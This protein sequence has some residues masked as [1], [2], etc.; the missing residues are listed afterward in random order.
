YG[1]TLVWVVASE[2]AIMNP[3]LTTHSV[4]ATLLNLMTNRIVRLNS[5]MEILPDLAE[6]WEVSGDGLVYTFYLRKGVKFHDGVELTAEDVIFTYKQ[7]MDPANDSPYRSHFEFIKNMGLIDQY[8]VRIVLSKPFEPFLAKLA[9]REILPKYI[10]NGKDLRHDPFNYHPIGT[11]PFKLKSWDKKTNRIELEANPDYF[12]GRPFLDRIVVKSY[13]DVS[14]LW[15]ALMRHEVDLMLFIKQE[16]YSVIEHDPAFKA[17]AVAGSMYYAIVYNLKDSIWHDRQLRQ[18]VAHGISVKQ[19]I[20]ALPDLDGL[21]ATGPFHPDSLGYNHQVQPFEFDPVKAKMILM[22]RGWQDMQQDARAGETG[23][24]RKDGRELEMRMLVDERNDTYKRIAQIIRQQLA[25]I[26]IKVIILLYEDENEVTREYLD[27]HK[28]QA[29]LRLFQGL[30]LDPYEAVGSWYSLSSEFAKFGNYKNEEI[31]R[32]I[33]LGNSSQNANKQTDIFKEI[34]RMIYDDQPACF[35]F[36]PAG[37]FA[38]NSKF[39]N[40]D[41][42]FNVY[43]PTYTIK[44]WYISEN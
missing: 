33:E 43:M 23:I 16:D 30:G 13:S 28:P 9:E 17:Y 11:G 34:H 10:L 21:R 19:I 36:F 20:K 44:D 42:Y 38:I 7:F 40:T 12:E 37:Y 6:R 5:G 31:D 18:A 27:Q 22:H 35:L 32:L 8:T 1:G 29:W 4:S 2:P 25:E 26:G 15:A 24:R 14:K 39:R 41:E 3:V